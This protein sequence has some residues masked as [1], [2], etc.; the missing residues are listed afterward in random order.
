MATD[1]KVRLVATDSL[2]LRGGRQLRPGDK[3]EASETDAADDMAVGYARKD[4][5][6]EQNITARPD[7]VP[8]KRGVKPGIKRGKYKRRDLRAQ[9]T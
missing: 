1:R 2:K 9:G 3:Y 8:K 6:D 7:P 4:L 5:N